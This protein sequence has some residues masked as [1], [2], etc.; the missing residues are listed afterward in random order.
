MAFCPAFPNAILRL[1]PRVFS[2]AP[3]RSRTAIIGFIILCAICSNLSPLNAATI[4][5]ASP[6][7][8]DVLAQVL[9]AGRGDTVVVP[10][11][12]AN[13]GIATLALT[14]GIRLMGAGRDGTFITGSGILVAIAPDATAIAN[15]ETIRVEGFTFDGNNASV[16]LLTVLGAG[17]SATKAFKNLAVG[18]NRFR[19]TSTPCGGSGAIRTNGQVRGAIFNN[20]FDRCNVI[21]KVLGNNDSG[22]EWANPA[23]KNFAYGTA[24]NL[25]FEGNTIRWSSAFNGQCNGWSETGQ[26]GRIVTRYNYY[27]FANSLPA[28]ATDAHDQ[29]GFQNWPGNGQT[30][31]MI[32]EYYGNTYVNFA[33]YR[34]QSHRGSWMVMH[35]NISTGTGNPAIAMMQYGPL[36]VGIAGSSGCTADV[37]GAS[38]VYRTEVNNTYVWNNIANGTIKNMGPWF[39]DGCGVSG[40]NVGYW[41]YNS[42]FN[43]STGIGRGT[44]APG[45]SPTVGVAYWKASTPTP[46]ANPAVVQSGRLYKCVSAGVWTDY[47][48]PYIYPHPLAS[49][50]PPPPPTPTPT[51]QPT[52]AP[53][54]TPQ[55]TATPTPTPTPVPL[56]TSFAS[57]AGVITNPFVIN[58][59]TISQPTETVDPTQGGRALYTFNITIPGDYVL[60]AMVDCPNGGSNS[61]FVNIDAEPS[62][63]MIWN[64][65]TTSGF[66]LEIASWPPSTTPKVWTLSAGIHQLIIRG[67]EAGTIL[68]QITFRTA[69]FAPERLRADP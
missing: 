51:P 25:F 40:E 6:S 2:P 20:D 54:P 37:P 13:W 32:G 46:T 58:S 15:E 48:T 41:N 9:I 8:S 65:S 35:N 68:G 61:L 63:A 56:G 7:F 62:P 45:G 49:G 53:T 50:I 52:P 27:D 55:P 29:H 36:A 5:A 31:T 60:S 24:D 21:F 47:Y 30:G 23:F 3:G 11:G 19:N 17:S 26:G 59:N 39:P 33:G 43:G 67:R 22:Q 16:N 34:W 28:G 10:S 57:T 1:Q 4:T 18:N 69:P 44:S 64:I 66:E 38:G 14:K 12:S 42:S